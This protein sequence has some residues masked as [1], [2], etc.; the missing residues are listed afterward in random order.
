MGRPL[1]GSI[2]PPAPI[3]CVLLSLPPASG[4]NPQAVG[5]R[6]AASRVPQQRKMTSGGTRKASLATS[7]AVPPLHPLTGR[8]WAGARSHPAVGEGQGFCDWLR[9]LEVGHSEEGSSGWGQDLEH[10]TWHH[11]SSSFPFLARL[12]H[13]HSALTRVNLQLPSLSHCDARAHPRAPGRPLP[14]IYTLISGCSSS[15]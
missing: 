1:V 4:T 8:V 3:L 15:K 10:L 2:E 6:T 11:R 5:R 9:R 13:P 14:H 7:V 12:S